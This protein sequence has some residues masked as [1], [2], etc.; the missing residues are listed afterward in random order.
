M[1]IIYFYLIKNRTRSTKTQSRE[2]NRNSIV[3][4][5]D[6][7][8]LISNATGWQWS[9]VLSFMEDDDCRTERRHINVVR[10][11]PLSRGLQLGGKMTP[12][13]HRCIAKKLEEIVMQPIG[14]GSVYDH[15]RHCQNL[16]TCIQGCIFSRNLIL[17]GNRRRHHHHVASSGRRVA[18]P[19]PRRMACLSPEVGRNRSGVVAELVCPARARTARTTSP[20]PAKWTIR[21]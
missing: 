5:C 18:P 1:L 8:N 7:K 16:H 15:I 21:S 2:N 11:E 9:G 14:S 12:E 17:E 20:V 3:S 13:C 6:Y 10:L 19:W 4:V